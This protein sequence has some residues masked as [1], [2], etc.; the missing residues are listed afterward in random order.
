MRSARSVGSGRASTSIDLSNKV[1]VDYLLLP[2]QRR[3]GAATDQLSLRHHEDRIAELLDEVQLVLDHQDRETVAPKILQVALD[4]VGHA[5]MHARHRLV[6]QQAARMQHERTHD[7]DQALLPAAHVACVVGLLRAHA[8]SFE[9]AARLADDP[10][11]VGE[12][13]TWT[14][15]GA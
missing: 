3:H 13:V 6:K 7:L 5:R 12:P 4:L 14:E 11:L 8:E 10:A 9:Q 2:P 1:S 15:Q